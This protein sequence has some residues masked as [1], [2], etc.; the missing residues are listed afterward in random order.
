V[1]RLVDSLDPGLSRYEPHDHELVALPGVDQAVCG[2]LLRQAAAT[3]TAVEPP[4]VL[5]LVPA[6]FG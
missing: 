1:V 3:A 2:E 4:Q 6:R 5:L